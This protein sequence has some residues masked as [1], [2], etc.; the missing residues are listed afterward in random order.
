MSTNNGNK[1]KNNFFP[2]NSLRRGGGI[3]PTVNKFL[4]IKFKSVISRVRKCLEPGQKIQ[5]LEMWRI[6][7]KLQMEQITNTF[8]ESLTLFKLI[9][10]YWR[11]YRMTFD[12]LQEILCIG[13][14]AAAVGSLGLWIFMDTFIVLQPWDALEDLEDRKKVLKLIITYHI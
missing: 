9:F 11:F 6:L 14:M 2:Y 10:Q 13:V 8:Q 5:M 1:A 4:T 3:N 7:E 12:V